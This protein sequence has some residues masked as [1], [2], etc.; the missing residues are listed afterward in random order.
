MS[1]SPCD[2]AHV[3][4]LLNAA[5]VEA[6]KYPS[7]AEDSG[8]SKR[9]ARYLLN[10]VIN[11]ATG[12]AEYSQEQVAMALLNMNSFYT[13]HTFWYGYIR[14]AV[15]FQKTLHGLKKDTST[16]DVTTEV[17]DTDHDDV[18]DDFTDS[19]DS[20]FVLATDE[21][22]FH[23][24]DEENKFPPTMLPSTESPPTDSMASTEAT[25]PSTDSTSPKSESPSTESPS[26]DS[27]SKEPSSLERVDIFMTEDEL[28]AFDN[29]DSDLECAD[30]EC[31]V[32]DFENYTGLNELIEITENKKVLRAAQHE[33]YQYRGSDLELMPFYVYIATVKVVEKKN[34]S[35]NTRKHCH[36]FMEG[37]SLAETHTQQ[38]RQKFKVPILT[39]QPPPGSGPRPENPDKKWIK[40][41]ERFIQYYSTLLFYWDLETGKA[42]C[43]TSWDDFLAK[44]NEWREGSWIEKRLNWLLNSLA[45]NLRLT[46]KERR[47]H[48]KF[49]FRAVTTN[50]NHD[51]S[52][53]GNFL[54]MREEEYGDINNLIEEY[55]LNNSSKFKN[56]FHSKR[57]EI[58]DNIL[59]KYN[60]LYT[61]KPDTET[62]P[63]NIQNSTLWSEW[64][65]SIKTFDADWSRK[66]TS[67]IKANSK[68]CDADSDDEMSEDENIFASKK[69]AEI[70]LSEAAFKDL[71][72][73]QK[74]ACM[75]GAKVLKKGEQLL[76]FLHG[77]PGVGKSHAAF[78]LSLQCEAIA[79][80]TCRTATTGVAATHIDGTTIDW[81]L[82]LR[83]SKKKNAAWPFVYIHPNRIT[84]ILQ[85]LNKAK[86]LILDEISYCSPE[87]FALIDQTLRIVLNE[88]DKPF[89]GLSVIILGDNFQLGPVRASAMYSSTIH[90]GSKSS[91]TGP[92]FAGIATF[93]KFKK[94]ELR[95]QVRSEDPAHTAR[96]TK[97]REN[98]KPFN[99]EFF[100]DIKTLDSEDLKDENWRFNAPFLVPDNY[101]KD[102]LNAAQAKLYAREHKLPVFVFYDQV[103]GK[104]SEIIDPQSRGKLLSGP[105]PKLKRYFVPTA[106]C[107]LRD[108]MDP[109]E[110]LANGISGTFH[111]LTWE[112][113]IDVTIPEDYQPGEEIEVPFPVSVNFIP[114]KGPYKGKV[115][116]VPLARGGRKNIIKLPSPATGSRPI[117]THMIDLA[118]AI[119]Y[120]KIQGSTKEK[121]ILV[122]PKGAKL[123]FEHLY[124]GFTRVKYG[125]HL[126][127]FP[128]ESFDHLYKITA[129]DDIRLWLNHYDENGNW[130]DDVIVA[131]K[132]IQKWNSE[133]GDQV[134]LGKKT[135]AKLRPL[136]LKLN[137]SKTRMKKQE[138]L[139][140][141][142]SVLE[143]PEGN[144]PPSK[145]NG[146]KQSGTKKTKKSRPSKKR[147]TKRSLEPE[148]GSAEPK[149][150]VPPDTSAAKKP[151]RKKKRK[152]SFEKSFLTKQNNLCFMNTA[153]NILL[154]IPPLRDL[155]T[156][157]AHTKA[158]KQNCIACAF[159]S[160]AKSRIEKPTETLSLVPIAR[161][162]AAICPTYTFGEHHDASEVINTILTI[163]DDTDEAQYTNVFDTK[164]RVRITEEI[165]CTVC[166]ECTSNPDIY[167]LVYDAQTPKNIFEA[168]PETIPDYNCPICNVSAGNYEFQDAGIV[169]GVV[170]IK[171]QAKKTLKVSTLNAYSIIQLKRGDNNGEKT[172][173]KMT[174]PNPLPYLNKKCETFAWTQHRGR[175]WKSGHWTAF[176]NENN[177]FVEYDDNKKIPTQYTGIVNNGKSCFLVLKN[178]DA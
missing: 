33:H 6:Q 156:T 146:K 111:S 48:A 95:T 15:D 94:F 34:V 20:D 51:N 73:C 164:I 82:N 173:H 139:D 92:E 28:N 151:P 21:E 162:Y 5:H 42:P 133:I 123:R 30:D 78:H 131:P 71:T 55:N 140:K 109:R 22:S 138:L 120:H 117:A 89:G 49:R 60:D 31:A 166:K 134:A 150:M 157:L 57:K 77:P 100:D 7:K 130:V 172:H 143:L 149:K 32:D 86:I 177:G 101:T 62:P 10:K 108:N 27:P 41:S 132:I 67:Q 98:E 155:Y 167:A 171:S 107:M 43:F 126:R 50:D 115:I 61:T 75:Y 65:E 148:T 79:W 142:N 88:L 63:D 17:A 158:C 80:K 19:E 39:L 46:A 14:D 56:S 153:F 9:N 59:D 114:K 45:S 53:T 72:V 124:V 44:I 91:A 106:P 160:L 116:P 159:E 93:K 35:E 40:A 3:L 104:S 169:P 84:R 87:K 58:A 69:E 154:S 119:T 110:K 23:S 37:H 1:K 99:A 128:M 161:K 36:D 70:D 18:S 8:E 11:R 170:A 38:I 26:T 103:L 13:S 90:L 112:D 122:L 64:S 152:S 66:M 175:K 2:L 85:R 174:F 118:F 25:A 163:L 47:L 24:S 74:R 121:V 76:L 105:I 136:A 145:K 102:A 97:L 54:G 52:N 135:M 129:N 144:P 147:G 125:E 4:P 137:I 165:K 29:Y 127:L 96:I 141:I 113:D 178:E 12:M 81:L 16:S 83:I 176:I 68:K 168:K